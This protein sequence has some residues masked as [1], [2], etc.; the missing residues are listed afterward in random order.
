MLMA[1]Y[2]GNE[3]LERWLWQVRRKRKVSYGYLKL[4]DRCLQ[5]VIL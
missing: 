1:F 3:P 4:R 5:L 2:R